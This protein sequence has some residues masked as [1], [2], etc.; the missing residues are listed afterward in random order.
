MGAPVSTVQLA[1]GA[2][3]NADLAAT[4]DN[5]RTARTLKVREGVWSIR[6]HSIV[7]CIVVETPEGLVVFDTGTNIGEGEVFLRE[8]RKLSAKPIL[9]IVYSHSHYTR[10]AKPIVDGAGRP[11]VMIIGHP[12]VEANQGAAALDLAPSRQRRAAL[13]FGN[14]LPQRGP[15]A[16]LGVPQ[17][18]AGAPEK[19]ASGHIAVTRPVADGERLMIGGVE[20]QFIHA[21][22]DT[23]DSLS[24]WIPSLSTVVTNV[25]AQHF[26]AMYTLR[27]E[28]FRE[29]RGVIKGYDDIRALNPEHYVPMHDDP[30]TG[31]AEIQHIL[32][33]HRD[34]YAFTFNQAV[35]GINRGWGPDD[36]VANIHLPDHLLKE[37]TLAQSYS[38]FD[39]A[40]RGI[41]R[42]LIGWFGEDAAGMHP[43]APGVLGAEIVAG[44][45]GMEKVLARAA[46]AMSRG[47]YALAAS[48]AGYAVDAD[49]AS[50]N[51]RQAKADALRKLGQVS[52]GSQGYNFYITQARELE[53]KLDTRPTVSAPSSRGYSG[54]A[55]LPSLAL[56]SVL[57]SRID[58]EKAA[59]VTRSL[60]VSFT[61]TKEEFTINVRR[62]VAEVVR[63]A[64]SGGLRLSTDR[65]TWFGLV[66]QTLKAD[67]IGQAAIQGGGPADLR[68]FLAMFD[69]V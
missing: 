17:P 8:I 6:D 49:P 47:E 33:A 16:R 30:V 69:P 2:I 1:N 28:P 60:G 9:A 23:D 62:G 38:E 4:R 63:G 57:E 10:G 13:Q 36:L 48:L 66:S 51:A 54:V 42:G 45:G 24:V 64:G 52:L 34:A 15:D 43:P 67:E 46:A 14:Y 40:L 55:Q 39:F 11:D 18:A 22:A 19:Q 58:P 7:N 20:F 12:G 37:P 50:K 68:A 31:A 29:P 59:A 5:T 65:R 21:Q 41:Y 32:T 27:G 53:G 35:R 61:D 26:F 56:V 44:F 25:T 3:V